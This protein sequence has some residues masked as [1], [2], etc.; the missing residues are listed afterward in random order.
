MCLAL[1]K[2]CTALEYI[3]GTLR[4]AG[5]GQESKPFYH[6]WGAPILSKLLPVS[7]LSHPISPFTLVSTAQILICS[8]FLHWPLTSP[9][10]I[11]YSHSATNILDL[12][13][14]ARETSCLTLPKPLNFFVSACKLQNW[15]IISIISN[16]ASSTEA[17]GQ[18]LKSLW[19]VAQVLSFQI[20]WKTWAKTFLRLCD[21]LL[22]IGV[23]SFEVCVKLYEPWP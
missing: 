14:R 16:S 17:S 5:S 23:Q 18:L 22:H 4:D 6:F 11:H 2:V 1:V 3:Q 13:I 15:P 7:P 12:W 9:F 19:C 10:P 21:F 8:V 20:T